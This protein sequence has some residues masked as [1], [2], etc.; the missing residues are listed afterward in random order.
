MIAMALMVTNKNILENHLY[1]FDGIL[2]RQ[3]NRGPIGDNITTIDAELVMIRGPEN[4]YLWYPG[5]QTNHFW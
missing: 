2:Y 5:Y 4:W 1:T 3:K